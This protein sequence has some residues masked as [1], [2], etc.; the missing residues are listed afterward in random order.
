MSKMVEML[1]LSEK[2]KE[3]KIAFFYN[4]HV[5]ETENIKIHEKRGGK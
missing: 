2:K 4:K 3:V 5:H 1:I